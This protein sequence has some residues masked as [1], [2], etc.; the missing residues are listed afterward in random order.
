MELQKE[1]EKEEKEEKEEKKEEE[2]EIILVSIKPSPLKTPS[3]SSDLVKHVREFPI[4]KKL[5]NN[6]KKTFKSSIRFPCGYLFYFI[7]FLLFYFL[8]I[9]FL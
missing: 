8:T 3:F 4:H 5:G 9:S 1:K 2:E 6:S 7:F